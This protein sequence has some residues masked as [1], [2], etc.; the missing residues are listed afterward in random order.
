MVIKTLMR[1]LKND[2]SSSAVA[3]TLPKQLQMIAGK[4]VIEHSASLFLEDPNCLQIVIPSVNSY[5]DHIQDLF[6][7]E[8][9]VTIV[10]AGNTR[11]ESVLLGLKEL[12]RQYKHNEWVMVHDAARPNLYSSDIEQLI[13]E[14]EALDKNSVDGVE[15]NCSGA[16]LA[17][18]V[19]ETLKLSTNTEFGI[20]IT[21][22]V[23]RLNMWNAKTPQMFRLIELSEAIEHILSDQEL[24]KKV[25]DE[26]S[27]M[28]LCNKNVH[29][30][31]GRSDNMKLTVGSDMK[32]LEFL[33]TN[34]K[35]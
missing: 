26:A 1:N 14:V 28:E 19:H 15:V 2:T 12:Q 8:Q 25:T 35:V 10:P 24:A 18:P 5:K 33:L 7:S 6:N 31:E 9:K 20:S 13:K 3:D 30:V 11:A 16:I 17:S 22:T 4:T 21:S 29:L 23:N 34:R 32:V 27:A